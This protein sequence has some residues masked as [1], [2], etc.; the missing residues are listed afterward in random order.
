ERTPLRVALCFPDVYEIGMSNNALPI[1]YDLLNRQP[2]VLCERVFTPWPDM[3]DALRQARL[4][5][6]SLET[7]YPLHAFDVLGF[8]LAYEQTYTNILETLDLGGIPLLSRDRDERHPLVIAGG[9]CALNPEPIADFIDVFGV[10]EGEDMMLAAVGLVRQAQAQGWSRQELLRRCLAV[11]GLYVPRFYEVS[12]Q[13]D[14][15]VAAIAPTVPEAP[16]RVVRQYVPQV[17]PVVARPVVPNLQTI[18]DRAAIEIKRGCT[19]GCRFCQAGMITRP[20]R[21]RSHEEILQGADELLRNTGYEELA[22]L[23][24]SSAD[25][26]GIDRLVAAL[27]GRYQRQPLNISLPSLR[28]DALSVELTDALTSGRGKKSSFTFAPEAGSARL[29]EV[30]N[31][32]VSE[33]QIE[34]AA[35]LAFHKGWQGIKLYFM[36]GLPTESDDDVLGIWRLCQRLL[37]IGREELRHRP[38]IKASV[39][40]FVPKPHTP[41]Q[42]M[43][44]DSF[45]RARHKYGLLRDNLKRAGAQLAW[46]EPEEGLIEAVLSRGDRRLGRAIA[47]AWELGCR[48]DSWSEHFHYE[49]WLQALRE[50]GLDP[51][52]YACRERSRDEVL[53]WDHIDCGVTKGYLWQEHLRTARGAGQDAVHQTGDC[54]TDACNACGLQKSDAV[55]QGKFVQLIISKKEAG[56]V[57]VKA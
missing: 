40:V 41:F 6:F 53:P 54:R 8:S 25:F 44:Q 10:G 23:S 32:A 34:A 26:P 46:T 24:L 21:E 51:A 55:C 5:L 1:F 52:F 18:H 49:R 15:T 4:P 33:E 42:W 12:Y 2:D 35:R 39:G 43:P 16:A 38:R 9:H 30:I 3:A 50:S 48:F 36:I 56:K 17:P 11:P 45:E 57:L 7:R 20:T 13:P 31:K 28:I 19:R 47:R 27:A 29:R 22:L 14:G 37:A